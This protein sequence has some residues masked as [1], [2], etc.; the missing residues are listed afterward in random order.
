MK[1]FS[2]IIIIKVAICAIIIK[3]DGLF[4]EKARLLLQENISFVLNNN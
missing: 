3:R 1:E 2:N 4:I